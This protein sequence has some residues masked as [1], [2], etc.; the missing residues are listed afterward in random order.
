MGDA[1]RALRVELGPD[2]VLLSS[3]RVAGGVEITAGLEDDEDEEPLLVAEPPRPS[4][5]A[6]PG[7]DAAA[8]AFHGVPAPLAGRL[9]AGGLEAAL[10]ATLRFAPIPEASGRPLMLVG[11][12]GA[13]KTLSCAKLAARRVLAGSEAPLIVSADGE[14]AGGTEQ[15]AGYARLMGTTLA[16]ALTPTAVAK[17]VARA[18]PGQAVLVDAPGLDPFREDQARA[19]H[20]L[21]AAARA[22]VLLVLP[23]GLDAAEASDL[24]L[25]FGALGATHLLPT[26]LDVTRRVGSILAAAATARLFLTEAGTAPSPVDGLQ[27][28]GP[29]W[30]A[31]RLRRR[32][33]LEQGASQGS[34]A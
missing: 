27:S 12:P 28:I 32:S 4:P 6:Q 7:P 8:L 21:A 11:P 29:A 15:L 13:G 34:P 5:V 30:L 9:L 20:E 18:V 24:A 10:E 17:A 3:R 19:L 16:V 31:A 23:A 2:A 1:M 25:A 22:A 14:R 33:H 26:R